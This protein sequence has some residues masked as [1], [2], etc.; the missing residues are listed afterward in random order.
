LKTVGYK[1]AI[2]KIELEQLASGILDIYR[3]KE[4]A[5]YIGQEELKEITALAGMK[6]PE[7]YKRILSQL[8]ADIDND[9]LLDA[10]KLKLLGAI[11]LPAAGSPDNFKG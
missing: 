7:I 11:L 9:T 3:E 2:D 5:S 10:Y 6:N 1:D 4:D 8:I